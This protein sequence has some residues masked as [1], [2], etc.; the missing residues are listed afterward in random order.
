MTQTI[1]HRNDEAP[2]RSTPR[3]MTMKWLVVLLALS[4]ATILDG[5]SNSDAAKPGD[6]PTPA[7]AAIT[8]PSERCGPGC[9]IMVA[10]SQ[11]GDAF[12]APAK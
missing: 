6:R 11:S 4:A 10:S 3:A 12:I 2:S 5:L 7:Q 9:A 1:S 8:L